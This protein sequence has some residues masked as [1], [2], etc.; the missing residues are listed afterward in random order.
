MPASP[1]LSVKKEFK[2][3]LLNIK[4]GQR[5][6]FFTEEISSQLGH[7]II[8]G[9]GNAGVKQLKMRKAFYIGDLIGFLYLYH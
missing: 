6:F 2:C 5:D 9:N 3:A 8:S 7:F 1:L 4:M